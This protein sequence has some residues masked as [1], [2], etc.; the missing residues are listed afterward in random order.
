LGS[1]L[2]GFERLLSP[3]RAGVF[4]NAAKVRF[5]PLGQVGDV[6]LGLSAANGQAAPGA[7]SGHSRHGHN[8]FA[9]A[10]RAD[11]VEN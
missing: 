8:T 2:D 1:A 5:P 3:V 7:D 11:I 6:R 9:E 4:A 10:S